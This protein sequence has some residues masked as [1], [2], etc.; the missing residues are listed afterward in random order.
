MS[1]SELEDA[2]TEEIME[3]YNKKYGKKSFFDEIWEKQNPE[4]AK[5][6]KEQK[7]KEIKEK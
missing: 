7:I 1:Q 6:L 5:A 2:R 4:E 3:I